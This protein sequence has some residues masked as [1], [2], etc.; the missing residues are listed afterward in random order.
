MFCSFT[1]LISSRRES[2]NHRVLGVGRDLCGSPSPTPCQKRGQ[3]QKAAE[4]LVQADLEYL[5]RSRLHHL[6][7][8]YSR[9]DPGRYSREAGEREESASWQ[10]VKHTWKSQGGSQSR[11]WDVRLGDTCVTHSVAPCIPRSPPASHSAVGYAG[12]AQCSRT[13]CCSQAS[14]SGHR[15]FISSSFSVTKW[16]GQAQH[17]KY[18]VNNCIISRTS[19]LK[20]FDFRLRSWQLLSD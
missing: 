15:S 17:K 10:L 19:H 11:I 4:D 16:Q 20:E 18:H 7:W 13:P 14:Q 9:L 8:R 1:T 3:L 6:L 12:T 5:Q 2:Q